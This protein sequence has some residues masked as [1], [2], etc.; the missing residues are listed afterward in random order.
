[1]NISKIPSQQNHCPCNPARKEPQS[2]EPLC[3]LHMRIPE[4]AR[5]QAKL[6]A[7]AS[8]VPFRQYVAWLLF[9]AKP[10]N[11]DDHNLAIA[12]SLFET[13]DHVAADSSL[14]CVR[15]LDR[16]AVSGESDDRG[17]SNN[18]IPHRR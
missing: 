15:E 3:N 4:T 8:G 14:H 7:V 5:R 12:T 10:I 6:A 9:Q 16:N 2:S 1:M 11:V 13:T 18:S 17:E